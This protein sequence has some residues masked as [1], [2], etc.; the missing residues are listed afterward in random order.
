MSNARIIHWW[1]LFLLAGVL[2]ARAQP[3]TEWVVEALDPQGQLE[4]NFATGEAIGTNGVI[5]RYGTS[6][7]MADRARVNQQTGETVTEGRVR[8]PIR[9]RRL[10]SALVAPG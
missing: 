2:S 4:Y 6:V 1:T 10:A 3:L 7:L 5:V 9:A 8:M